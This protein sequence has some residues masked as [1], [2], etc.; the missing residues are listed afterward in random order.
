M[1]KFN[2]VFSSGILIVNGIISVCVKNLIV[3]KFPPILLINNLKTV[4]TIFNKD[5]DFFYHI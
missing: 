1:I 5:D 3:N 2:S 4:Q